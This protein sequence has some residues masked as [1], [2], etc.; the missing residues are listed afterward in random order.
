MKWFKILDED[1][2]QIKDGW[3]WIISNDKVQL[4]IALIQSIKHSLQLFLQYQ[5]LQYVI[6]VKYAKFI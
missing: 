6:Y 2:K 5:S 3:V 4:T 1:W